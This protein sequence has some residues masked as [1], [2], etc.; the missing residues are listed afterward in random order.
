[1]FLNPRRLW[2]AMGAITLSSLASA[3]DVVGRVDLTEK[4]G[5]TLFVGT[6]KN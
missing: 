5:K 3:G 6:I 2:M 1:M 4:G